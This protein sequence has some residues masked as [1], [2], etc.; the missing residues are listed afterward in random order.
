MRSDTVRV[1]SPTHDEGEG[2]AMYV[3]DMAEFG[4]GEDFV[5][6]THVRTNATFYY[7]IGDTDG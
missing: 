6:V 3:A 4:D 1:W 2:G 5:R 7:G